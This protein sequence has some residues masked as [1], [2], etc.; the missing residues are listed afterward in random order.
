MTTAYPR[1]AGTRH[2]RPFYHQLTVGSTER[3]RYGQTHECP[4]QN[5]SSATMRP[6][7]EEVGNHCVQVVVS[8]LQCHT[9]DSDPL[10]VISQQHSNDHYQPTY[11]HLR[12]C[13]VLAWSC[14][15]LWSPVTLLP[16]CLDTYRP[17]CSYDQSAV[18]ER[19]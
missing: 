14:G 9:V 10:F 6:K 7:P 12:A 17:D 3:K 16:S 5:Y 1:R 11:F 2:R 8:A 4:V 19:Q 18:R 13:R 15:S